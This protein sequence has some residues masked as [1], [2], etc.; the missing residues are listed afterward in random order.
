MRLA[1]ELYGTVAGTLEGDPRTFDFTPSS[2]GID[3]FGTNSR[4]LSV[5]IPLAD[6]LPRHH[7]ARRRNWFAELLPEGDQ[8]DYLL[9]QGG[10]LKGDTPAFLARYGRD[11]AGALQLWNLDDPAEPGTSGLHPVTSSEVRALLEDPIGSPLAN[12]PEAGKSSLGGV[13][14]KIVLVKTADGWAQALEGY[15]TT[16]ILKPRLGGAKQTVIYDE[17]YG[18]RLARAIGLAD[19]STS[20]SDFA[21]LPALVIERY[22]RVNGERV[23]QED[24]SQALGASGN[25]KYQELGGVVSLLR[26]AE[27]LRRHTPAEDLLRLARMVVF[28]VAIGNLDLHTKNIGLLH[29]ADGEVRLAPAYDIVPQAHQQNDG[30]LALSVNGKYR[31][32]ELTRDDLRAEL[33]RWGLRRAY[34]LVEETLVELQSAVKDELPFD[35]AYPYLQQTISVFIDNLL[36]GRPVHGHP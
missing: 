20:I 4:V 14:P 21:D 31:H 30:K 25:E 18:S 3:R 35:D 7:A 28:A 15:P 29:S 17:E 1:V 2:E 10:L 5:A 8:Y 19:F 23:H 34:P 32:A 36:Y 24:L 13:Q 22:D 27:V 12:E 16:H 11:V 26:V 6:V 9:A 33:A